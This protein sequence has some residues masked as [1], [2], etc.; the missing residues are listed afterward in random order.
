MSGYLTT[1]TTTIGDIIALALRDANV[2]GEGQTASASQTRDAFVKLN[3]MLAQWRRRRWLIYHTIDVSV[4]CT[5]QQ[6][7]TI[8]PGGDVPLTYRPAKLQA[9][10][11]RQYVNTSSPI[12]FPLMVLE[13]RKDYNRIAMK[14]LNTF[15][16]YV[17][18]DPAYPVGV[19][20]PYPVPS[21]PNYELHF[22]V[23]EEIGE[24][25]SVAE[26]MSLPGEYVEAVQ[27]NLALRLCVQNGSPVSPDLRQLAKDSL[28]T[29]K[30]INV[31]ISRLTMPIGLPGK[32]ASYNVYSDQG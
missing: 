25:T 7:Y 2:V 32:Q 30:Q 19:L 28:D 13:S 16:K 5:G 21:L 23:M 11:L 18:Y 15:T 14:T 9:A 31:V 12:D 24:F 22:S 17:F 29:V 6:S 8:G 3:W 27:T 1:G 4:A 20:W 26:N 10:F